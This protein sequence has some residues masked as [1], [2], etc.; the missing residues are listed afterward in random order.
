MFEVLEFANI[1]C[2]HVKQ[3]CNEITSIM[4]F[5]QLM[6]KSLSNALFEH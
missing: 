5:S 1:E 3:K 4:S 6:S 2:L